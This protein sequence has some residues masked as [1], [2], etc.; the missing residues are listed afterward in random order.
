MNKQNEQKPAGSGQRRQNNRS[1]QRPQQQQQNLSQRKEEAVYAFI[2]SQNLNISIQE[3]GWKLDWTE[4][5]KYLGEKL[6][7]TK[8]F[9]FIGYVPG[10][11]TM[12]SILQQQ[13]YILIFRPTVDSD[14]GV[15]GNIDV[16]LVLRAMI[17]YPNYDKAVIVTGDGD[18]HALIDHLDSHGKLKTLM[19]PNKE[20]YSS[21]F[22]RFES[23]MDFISTKRRTLEYKR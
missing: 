8:A 23:K 12:Y 10:N 21:L 7:V 6:G 20:R 2:D 13:G 19:I 3:K 4:F 1:R 16:E 22:K 11:E 14:S 15:K 18:F 17:E 9:L 5:R